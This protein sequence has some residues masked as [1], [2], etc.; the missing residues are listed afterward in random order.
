MTDTIVG[1]NGDDVL[2]PHNEGSV[3]DGGD[4]VDTLSYDRA[5]SGVTV[6]LAKG[7]AAKLGAQNQ[8]DNGS[9]E[10]TEAPVTSYSFTTPIGWKASDT[11]EVWKSG[12]VE[13]VESSKG[14]H[15]LELDAHKNGTLDEIYQDIP[16][17]AGETF[18][19]SLDIRARQAGPE[20]VEIYWDGVLIATVET[21]TQEWETVTLDLPAASADTARLAFK[22]VAGENT[23]YGP[24]LDDVKLLASRT[25]ELTSIENVIGSRHDDDIT[26]SN[27]ANVLDGKSGD[28]VLKGGKGKD[29][30]TGGAGADTVD[31]GDDND[32]ILIK[33]RDAENDV[34]KGGSGVDT[35]KVSDNKT[36]TLKT[37]DDAN[38][39]EKVEGKLQGT[40]KA[41][42]L[43]FRKVQT[44]T[45]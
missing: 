37:F 26:G 25:D 20:S 9:F 31:G 28:D 17:T 3:I 7:T 5:K 12:K 2:R 21:T 43:D 39:I 44:M 4:G 27:A 42:D 30:L 41:D 18:Q 34:I 8:V 13:G 22:E 35:L 38:S 15:H 23:S 36:A 6:N 40:N 24:L 14:D 29:V 19:L 45:G 33:G 11:G 10:K 32:L 1:S 16:V